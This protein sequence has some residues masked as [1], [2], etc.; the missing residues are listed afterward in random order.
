VPIEPFRDPVLAA[1]PNVRLIVTEH[2]GHCGFFGP[3]GNGHDGY[4]AER[5]IVS[6]AEEVCGQ[7]AARGPRAAAGM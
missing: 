4:W 1:N 7:S 5:M 3:S 6:F 2:G